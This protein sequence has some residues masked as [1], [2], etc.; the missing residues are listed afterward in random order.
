[1]EEPL[2]ES[3]L[4]EALRR[5][6]PPAFEA[7][8]RQ[9]YR[10]VEDMVLR[11][12]G[13]RN[14]AKDVFQDGLFVLV[15]K[16][17]EPAFVLSV[18]LSTFLYAVTRNIWLKKN[19]KSTTEISFENQELAVFGLLEEDAETMSADEQEQL[20]T[21]MN[22]KLQELEAGCRSIL[23]YAFY[24][25]CSHAEIAKLMGYT[26]AFVKV[27]KFRCLEYLRKLLKNTESFKNYQ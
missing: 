10:M 11:L 15:K 7:L 9:Y 12:S 25:K 2:T 1:M 3:Y 5:G 22:E 18:K 16:L 19:G 13:T 14:D 24:Q 26:E 21:T 23:L 27:K 4:I 17:R 8:Y 20:I 6:D